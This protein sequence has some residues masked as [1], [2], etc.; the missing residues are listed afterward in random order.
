MDTDEEL[1]EMALAQLQILA[2]ARSPRKII[3][4]LPE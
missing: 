1:V 2:E 4:P 3:Y